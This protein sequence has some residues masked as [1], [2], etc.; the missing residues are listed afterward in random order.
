[1]TTCSGVLPDHEPAVVRC[2]SFSAVSPVA[3]SP[4][5]VTTAADFPSDPLWDDIFAGIVSHD[6]LTVQCEQFLF[7]D[8]AGGVD[9]QEEAPHT[10]SMLI[11]KL[12]RGSLEPAA[13]QILELAQELHSRSQGCS[14]YSCSTKQLHDNLK[15]AANNWWDSLRLILQLWLAQ[16]CPQARVYTH[17]LAL[18][19]G[20]LHRECWQLLHLGI[21]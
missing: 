2:N 14:R 18:K 20:T 12:C 19:E 6:D 17:A 1:M 10:C 4:V 11:P 3:H 5:S 7:E 13:R 9:V 21:G 16:Q 15:E 8:P